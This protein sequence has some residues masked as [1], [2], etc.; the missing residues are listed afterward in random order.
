MLYFIIY[1]RINVELFVLII[2]R[3]RMSKIYLIKILEKIISKKQLLNES[4]L[5]IFKLFLKIII[6]IK[7]RYSNKI[8]KNIKI[9][10]LYFIICFILILL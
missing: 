7:H 10:H 9:N 5:D 3:R 6:T 8:I 2:L 4:L 1:F